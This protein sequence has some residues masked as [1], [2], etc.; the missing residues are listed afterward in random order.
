MALA[1][2]FTFFPYPSPSLTN[3]QTDQH[4]LKSY[5][6]YSSSQK[7]C[8]FKRLRL[9]LSVQ[10]AP[11]TSVSDKALSDIQNSG[12]IACLRAN[13]PELAWEAACA[14]LNGGVTVLEIVMTTPGVLGVLQRLVLQYPEKTIGVGTVLHAKDAMSAID[15]GAKFLMSPAIVKDVMD[16]V[17][18]TEVLY[19]P[20]VMTP[21]EILSARNAGAEIV[22]VRRFMLLS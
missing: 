22:K 9:K 16:Y 10:A 2:S 15:C 4:F 7:C 13:G 11:S 12:V 21:T 14:A 17:S 8:C 6:R 20:G 18:E 1:P 5:L 3:N 19:I